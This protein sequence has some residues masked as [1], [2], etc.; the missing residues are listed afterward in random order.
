M[1]VCLCKYIYVYVYVNDI[2]CTVVVV[3]GD[4]GSSEEA[5]SDSVLAFA[6]SPSGQLLA[7]T[8]DSKRLVLFTCEGSWCHVSTR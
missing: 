3:S 8:D 7:L 2:V 1:C 5:G 4:D 6:A